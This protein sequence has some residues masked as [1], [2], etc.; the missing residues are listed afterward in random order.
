[1]SLFRP[2]R[3]REEAE[4]QELVYLDGEREGRGSHFR[5]C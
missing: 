5:A 4:N 2:E 3:E 1:M